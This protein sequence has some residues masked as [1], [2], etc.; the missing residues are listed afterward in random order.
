MVVPQKFVIIS[1]AR[2]R[3]SYLVQLLNSHP[4]VLCHSEFF[5]QERAMLKLEKTVENAA[6]FDV[7][8]RDLQPQS[9]MQKVYAETAKQFPHVKAIGGKLLLYAYQINRGLVTLL[10]CNPRVIFLHRENKLAWY[11]SL[12]I[13]MQTNIWFANKTNA[14]QSQV[15]FD[16]NEYIS[17]VEN[18]ILLDSIALKLIHERNLEMIAFEYEELDRQDAIQKILGFLQ[19]KDAPLSAKTVM[20][21]S[22]NILSRFTNPQAVKSFATLIGKNVWLN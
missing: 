7:R 5:H 4:E 12:K 17:M 3:S 2:T 20:Q 18:Q 1:S 8:W 10:D 19:L 13:A 22:K 14:L 9:F 11:S 21:N 6:L 16:A 15:M